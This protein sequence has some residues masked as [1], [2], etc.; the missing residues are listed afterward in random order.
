M[1]IMDMR[2]LRFARYLFLVLWLVSAL[3]FFLHL[4]GAHVSF[5]RY[6]S[7]EFLAF[8]VGIFTFFVGSIA[9]FELFFVGRY[10]HILDAVKDNDFRQLQ[11]ALRFN[12]DTVNDVDP[13][14]HYT[15]L[16]YAIA[17]HR[18]QEIIHLLINNGAVLDPYRSVDWNMDTILWQLFVHY[19]NLAPVVAAA[20]IV[21]GADVNSVWRLNDGRMCS[22]LQ[23]ALLQRNTSSLILL[24][25]RAG[26]D[27][28][29]REPKEDLTPLMYA[30]R[31]AKDVKVLDVLI[32]SGALPNATNRY[33]YTPLLVAAEYNTNPAIIEALVTL[34]CAIRP[35]SVRLHGKVL[36]MATP[37]RIAVIHNT[38]DVVEKLI[39]LSDSIDFVDEAGSSLLFIAAASNTDVRVLELLIEKGCPMDGVNIFNATALMA[40][41]YYNTNLNVILFFINNGA[42]PTIISDTNRKASDFVQDNPHLSADEIAYV[43]NVLLVKENHFHIHGKRAPAADFRKRAMG[44][45]DKAASS[46]TPLVPTGEQSFSA[47]LGQDDRISLGDVLSFVP[48]RDAGDADLRTLLSSVDSD[49]ANSQLSTSLKVRRKDASMSSPPSSAPLTSGVM[50]TAHPWLATLLSDKQATPYSSTVSSD[51]D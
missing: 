47:G 46:F 42:D 29:Y 12:K 9:L 17:H 35:Y 24:L 40:A 18:P 1:M 30:A 33:G 3:V 13:D 10:V 39:N 14:T 38:I 44:F 22:L 28:H 45:M 2:Y 51:G 48:T 19:Q 37:L 27:V 34:G 8:T 43:R 16:G 5:F 20:I 41:A 21:R 7:L 25:L 31:Y 50:V 15:P 4:F 26:A 11:Y 49:S 32:R 23:I 6:L 36:Q